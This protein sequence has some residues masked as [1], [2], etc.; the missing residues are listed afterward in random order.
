MNRLKLYLAGPMA[1]CNVHEKTTW[2]ELLKQELGSKFTYL[3]PVTNDIAK[4]HLAT[5]IVDFDLH[6]L[7]LAD[8]VIAN[9][10]QVSVGTTCE[11]VYA[12]LWDKIV[13]LIPP[14]SLCVSAWHV[15]HSTKLFEGVDLLIKYLKVAKFN[16][17]VCGNAE[18]A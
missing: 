3:D 8:I 4:W 12:K 15:H 7:K 1:G 13:L 6:N 10:W 17:E 9:C 16:Y 14:D 11:I 2:R 5:E 18:E